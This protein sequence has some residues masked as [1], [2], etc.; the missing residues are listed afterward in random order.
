MGRIKNNYVKNNGKKIF[1]QGQNEF[2]EK[3][4]ENKEIV[5]KFAQIPSKKLRN[6]IT[7]YVTRLKKNSDK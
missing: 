7:G 3:F 1:D 4:E 6:I 2:T 5:Q